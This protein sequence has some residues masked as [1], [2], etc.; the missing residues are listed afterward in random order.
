MSKPPVLPVVLIWRFFSIDFPVLPVGELR[1][2][3]RQPS[4][5]GLQSDKRKLFYRGAGQ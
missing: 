2:V 1:K 3:I 5:K 4:V